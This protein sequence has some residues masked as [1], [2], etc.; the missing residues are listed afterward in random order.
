VTRRRI[1]LL[2][3][4][5]FAAGLVLYAP[6][7]RGGFVGDDYGYVVNDA[8]I[9]DLDGRAVLALLDPFGPPALFTANY[10]PVHLLAHGV[11]WSLF[12]EETLGYHV[13]NVAVHAVASALLALLFLRLGISQ[14]GS[15]LLAVLFFVHPANVESVAWIFQLK[16]SLAL[17]LS[18]AA[19]LAFR[20]RPLL[21]WGL[22]T[23]ALL[24]K[25]SA[26]YAFAVAGLQLAL[27]GERER[28]PWLWLGAWAVSLVYAA[29]PEFGAFDRLGHAKV[30]APYPDVLVHARSIVAYAARYLAMAVSGYGVSAFQEPPR[31]GSWTDPWFLAGLT[32]LGVL[33]ARFALTLRRRSP[34]ALFWA[35]AAAAY[36]PVSQLFPFLYPMG[37]RY[38]YYVL[39]GL[40]GAAWFWAQDAVALLPDPARRVQLRQA[41]AAGLAVV[42]LVF[43]WQSYGR[44]AIW[45]SDLT[46]SLDAAAHFPDG[47]SGTF[48][49]AR[50]AA[51]RGDREAALAALEALAGRGYDGFLVVQNDPGLAPLR[52]DPRF[53]QAL[54][55]TAEN[56]L[57]V[58]APRKVLIQPDLRMRAFAH[59]ARGERQQALASM[60][61]ALAAGG[62][63]DAVIRSE[64]ADLRAE[65]AAAPSAGGEEGAGEGGRGGG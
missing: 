21:A 51:Q 19:L 1:A 14:R 49:R 65:A 26:S 15:L 50:R 33:A 48:L 64:L 57:R 4:G 63:F 23:L 2:A 37:D 28:G 39:P 7:L 38:L 53:Q 41:G 29:V 9:H 36:A 55:Q 11:E 46:V 42:A 52:G 18:V 22:F 43:A 56:W 13:V 27:R 20:E 58:V 24:S 35:W 25:F 3:L 40:L 59:R 32:L 61:Q 47:F 45:R 8:Y 31:A 17:G 34:E 10:A 12:G 30:L 62:P 6:A 54:A 16:T 44:A 5:L 60:Q